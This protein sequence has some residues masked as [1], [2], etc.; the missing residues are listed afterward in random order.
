MLVNIGVIVNV[1]TGFIASGSNVNIGVTVLVLVFS[2]N[3]SIDVIVDVALVIWSAIGVIIGASSMS[4]WMLL[5]VL[6]YCR[7]YN[8]LLLRHVFLCCRWL[9]T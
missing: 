9:T 3:V 7:T 6:R 8:K 4:V 2:A 1:S 5:L